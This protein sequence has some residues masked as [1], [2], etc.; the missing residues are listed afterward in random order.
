MSSLTEQEQEIL[1]EYASTFWSDA[2][3]MR[4]EQAVILYV[5]G[6]PN[7]FS[8]AKLLGFYDNPERV[9]A[10]IE[11]FEPWQTRSPVSGIANGMMAVYQKR[12]DKVE[13]ARKMIEA[14]RD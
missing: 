7:N 8:Y 4:Y 1:R 13:K 3:V 6:W 2:Q 5:D 14:L 9:V 10:A 11:D 12:Y